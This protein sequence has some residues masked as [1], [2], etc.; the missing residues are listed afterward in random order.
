[1]SGSPQFD[2]IKTALERIDRW[3]PEFAPMVDE[4]LELRRLQADALAAY[5]ENPWSTGSKGQPVEHPRLREYIALQVR[6]FQLSEALLLTPRGRARAGV[7]AATED[8]DPF[9]FLDAGGES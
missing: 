7:E 4:L 5:K 2:E 3:H 9:E 6:V 1:M 8:H